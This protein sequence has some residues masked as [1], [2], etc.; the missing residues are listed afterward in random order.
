MCRYHIRGFKNI[1]VNVDI[2]PAVVVFSNDRLNDF[3]MISFYH[4]DSDT[5]KFLLS[6]SKRLIGAFSSD[7]WI[8]MSFVHLGINGHYSIFAKARKKCV[9]VT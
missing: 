3:Q 6:K 5:T 9:H 4:N 7:C 8:S 1:D 2:V